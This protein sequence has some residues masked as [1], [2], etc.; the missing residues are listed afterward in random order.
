MGDSQLT[1]HPNECAVITLNRPEKLNSVSKKM[2]G[3]LNQYLEEISKR[4]DLKFLII[5]GSGQK[6]FCS[7]GDLNDFHGEMTEEEAY[8]LLQP[9]K[10]VLYKIASIHIPT[11]AWMNGLARGGGLEIASACDF[12]F[13][14]PN[15][16]FGFIQGKLGIS[17]GWGGGT[18]LYERINPQ[19]AFQWM[20]EADVKSTDELLSIGFIQK[21]IT[22][23][24]ISKEN[25]VLE[26]FFNR[27]CEQMVH[28]KNQR[29][30]KMPLDQ[31]NIKMDEEVKACSKLWVSDDHKKAVKQ[32]LSKK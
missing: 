3:E 29:L 9:M 11:I 24:E 13:A 1:I 25:P 31:L 15:Q 10:E 18:L 12:R 17:T 4:N 20:I 8:Q 21:I 28:W 27:S 30:I 2:I 16:S 5:T 14:S 7:G 23:L 22:N 32:F 26:A 6:A 19:L